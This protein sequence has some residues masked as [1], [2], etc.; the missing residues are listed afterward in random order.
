MAKKMMIC[1]GWKDC[2]FLREGRQNPHC[3]PH[4]GTQGCSGHC[5]VIG[6]LKDV[7]CRET[8]DEEMVYYK[9]LHPES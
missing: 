6:I 2:R 5:L 4:E 1:D 3:A 9:L 8:S 7:V